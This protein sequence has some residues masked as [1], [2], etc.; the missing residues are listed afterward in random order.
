MIP[1]VDA[2]SVWRGPT[3]TIASTS[4]RLR[5]RSRSPSPAPGERRPRTSASPTSS[6]SPSSSRRPHRFGPARPSGRGCDGGVVRR[7]DRARRLVRPR[8]PAGAAAALAR[9]PARERRPLWR[10]PAA[11]RPRRA[12]RA[13]SMPAARAVALRPS[14]ATTSRARRSH[15]AAA[16][17]LPA[18]SNPQGS[19]RRGRE[20]RR[21]G[22]SRDRP[23]R[24]RLTPR[25]RA[26]APRSVGR[27]LGVASRPAAT[28]ACGEVRRR[29]RNGV[30]RSQ[31][32]RAASAVQTLR[33]RGRP[34]A[35]PLACGGPADGLR[36]STSPSR[37]RRKSCGC[38]FAIAAV[39]RADST[40]AY[41]CSDAAAARQSRR[42]VPVAGDSTRS[43]R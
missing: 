33:P 38:E 27:R 23:G 25:P 41:A 40:K 18:V 26:H 10:Q 16:G 20:R 3:N 35:A 43:A 29:G 12:A 39:R 34:A 31:T 22:R 9:V 42:H 32:I 15:S 11:R 30:G 4:G 7:D 19:Y 5:A 14:A 17:A 21:P 1:W 6:S 2:Y 8:R 13:S 36:H 28:R 24:V 37:P